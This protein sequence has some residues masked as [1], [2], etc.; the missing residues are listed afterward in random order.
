MPYDVAVNS[1]PPPP[2]LS[3]SLMTIEASL[4]HLRMNCSKNALAH[5]SSLDESYL[6]GEPEVK[7]ENSIKITVHYFLFSSL[8]SSTI[9]EFPLNDRGSFTRDFFIVYNCYYKLM[10]YGLEMKETRVRLDYHRLLLWFF[11]VNESFQ[12][13]AMVFISDCFIPYVMSA[14]LKKKK[15]AHFSHKI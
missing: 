1:P 7:D 8:Q 6:R 14:D 3:D 9:R 12:V 10:N 4:A 2:T 11:I 13:Y 5:L 15:R